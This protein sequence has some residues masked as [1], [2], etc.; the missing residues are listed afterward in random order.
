M[1]TTGF[2]Y[3][4]SLFEA[5]MILCFGLA[6]PFN[7]QKSYRSRTVAGKSIGFT[8]VIAIGY[9]AGLIH[10]I[11]YSPDLVMCLYVFNLV[12]VAIDITLYLRNRKLDLKRAQKG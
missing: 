9:V 10:K 12:M 6:W 4:K 3:V 11:L 1:E 2:F 7:I 8:V 5:I